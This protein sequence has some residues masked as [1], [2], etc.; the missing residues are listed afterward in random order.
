MHNGEALPISSVIELLAALPCGAVLIDEG[1]RLLGVN[2]RAAEMFGRPRETLVGGALHELYP[3][4]EGRA[5]VERFLS[6]FDQ[7]QEIESYLLRP[8]GA[9]LPVMLAGRPLGSAPPRSGFRLITLI[10]ISQHKDA[11]ASLRDGY[12][13]IARLSDTVLEQALSLQEYSRTLERRVEERTRDLHDANM[14][15]I[16]MLAVAS[17]AKD[18]DTGAHVR[19]IQFFAEVLGR[20][21]GLPEDESRRI[22]YSAILH[23]VGKIHVPDAILLKPGKLDTDEWRVMREHPVT[24]ERILPERP[25]FAVARQIARSHHENWDGS[26]YPD[27]LSQD[28]IP[29]TARIVH[30]VD[31]YDA[32]VSRRPYKPAWPPADAIRTVLGGT[33]TL[34]D[35]QVVEAFRHATEQGRFNGHAEPRS[36]T[37][38]VV[39][40]EVA[41]ASSP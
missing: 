30:M 37:I 10:D 19:R 5:M 16:Y 33:G 24:G 23:D 9:R 15:A 17:E 6:R 20:E 35:P 34:F 41:R 36:S 7:A 32:L 18:D 2:D 28:D 27:G 38:V 14:D 3:D 25:F 8:D 40:A 31:V 21:L 29:L 11:E 39:P 13:D 1:G 22:G 12:R 26:G 4:A